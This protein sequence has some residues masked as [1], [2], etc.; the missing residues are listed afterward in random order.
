[1][2]QTPDA[3]EG[4]V[5]GAA[6]RCPQAPQWVTLLASTASQPLLAERSQSAKPA[7]HTK[8]Q[9]PPTQTSVALARIGQVTPQAPQLAGSM[10]VLTH[11]PLHEA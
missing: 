11:A 6:Q 4:T 2:P 10:R 5:L 1:M 9:A 7:L 3:Q 8:L